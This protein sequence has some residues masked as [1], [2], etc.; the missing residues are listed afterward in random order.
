MEDD[1]KCHAPACESDPVHQRSFHVQGYV[2]SSAL[3]A[4]ELRARLAETEAKLL[5]GWVKYLD[6]H[7]PQVECRCCSI[8]TSLRRCCVYRSILEGAP[9]PG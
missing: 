1:L 6:D 7:L 4:A 9:L 8:N 5:R 3:R 2:Q